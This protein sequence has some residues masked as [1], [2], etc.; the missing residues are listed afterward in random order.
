MKALGVYLKKHEV[1]EYMRKVDTGG[2]GTIEMDEFMCLM[3]EVMDKRDTSMEFQNIFQYYD[4]D[5][6]G[7]ITLNNLRECSEALDIDDKI[8]EEKL[9]KMIEV[10]DQK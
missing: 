3:T 8:T 2:S 7:K 6:S 5:D 1:I 4:N 9:A 10:A